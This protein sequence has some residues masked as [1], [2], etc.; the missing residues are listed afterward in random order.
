MSSLRSVTTW[1]GRKASVQ[2]DGDRILTASADET[3]RLWLVR[4]EDIL[5]LVDERISRK[6]TSEERERFA[7]LLGEGAGS[8]R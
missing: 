2:A 3:A 5:K 4:A 1:A 7:D 6:L 8:G